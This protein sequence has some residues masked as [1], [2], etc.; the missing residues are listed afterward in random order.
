MQLLEVVALG[1]AVALIPQSLAAVNRRPDIRYVPVADATPY[2]VHL[3]WSEGSK[4]PAVRAFVRAALD[5]RAEVE[6]TDER[7]S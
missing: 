5:I 6:H 1:M 4:A 3:A 2:A 7:V